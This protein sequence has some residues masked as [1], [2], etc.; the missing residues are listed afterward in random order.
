MKRIIILSILLFFAG[1]GGLYAQKYLEMMNDPDANFYDIQSEADLVLNDTIWGYRLYEAGNTITSTAT[2][3][4]GVGTEV[5]FQAGDEITLQSGFH[6]AEGNTFR[7]SIAACSQGGIPKA[8][9]LSGTYAGPMPGLVKN[10][11]NEIAMTEDED[12]NTDIGK[13]LLLYPNPF[14][15]QVTVEFILEEASPVTLRI[16]DINGR[17]MKRVLNGE[18]YESGRY[19]LNVRSDHWPEGL[20]LC[21]LETNAGKETKKIVLKR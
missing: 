2:L 4:G 6:A 1:Y 3:Q 11:G 13:G 10:T 15:S 20:Y 18:A 19:L 17:E 12:L 5:I 9:G 7:V 21:R 16:L 8:K 14:S